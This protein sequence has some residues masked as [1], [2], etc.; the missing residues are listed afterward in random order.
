M[1][2]FNEMKD[3]ICQCLADEPNERITAEAALNHTFLTRKLI[4]TVVDMTILPS[5]ILMLMDILKG[6]DPSELEGINLM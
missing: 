3:L 5:N 1:E 6:S 4:P 2:I